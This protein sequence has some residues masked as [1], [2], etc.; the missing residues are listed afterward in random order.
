MGIG[1]IPAVEKAI[2]KSGISIADLD[3]LEAN[4]AFAVLCINGGMGMVMVVKKKNRIL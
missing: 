4:E 1:V 2:V 3:L